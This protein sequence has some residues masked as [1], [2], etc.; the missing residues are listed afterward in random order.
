MPGRKWSTGS[1]RT[2]G[3]LGHPVVRV[4]LWPS[5]ISP[6]RAWLPTWPDA[7][8][9]GTSGPLASFAWSVRIR[10]TLMPVDRG[11]SASGAYGPFPLF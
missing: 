11:G 7:G 1:L 10:P 8:S 6:V 2:L 4:Y 5:L 9:R 3:L